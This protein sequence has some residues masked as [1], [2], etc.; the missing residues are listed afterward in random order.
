M[1]RKKK[2]KLFL[3]NIDGDKYYTTD[4]KLVQMRDLYYKWDNLH[5]L[6]IMIFLLGFVVGIVPI[7]QLENN[8]PFRWWSWLILGI[9]I[10]IAV[11]SIVLGCLIGYY[12]EKYGK[13]KDLYMVTKEYRQQKNKY[14]K[15]AKEKKE[16]ELKEKATDL[17]ESYEILEDKQMSKEMKIDLLKSYIERGEKRK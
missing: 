3:I 15:L 12:S 10:L 14:I 6:G 16:K 9:A 11:G 1:G 13:Y 8:E 2:E 7:C 4:K 5:G 17:V